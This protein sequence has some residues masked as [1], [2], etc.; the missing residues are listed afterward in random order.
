MRIH[1][2][3]IV[4]PDIVRQYTSTSL[5]SIRSLRAKRQ[6][7]TTYIATM[8]PPANPW[9]FN[10]ATVGIGYVIS[11]RNNAYYTTKRQHQS[12]L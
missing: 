8:N 5:P 4:E 9:P 10:N 11:R 12:I 7:R 3:V 2:S 6:R 1:T